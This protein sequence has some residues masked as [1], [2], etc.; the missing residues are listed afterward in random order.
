MKKILSALLSL[1]I[2][3][4]IA[5]AF[6]V[7]A[8]T[9]L[10]NATFESGLG[11]WTGRGSG[12]QVALS[13]SASVSG[14]QSASVTN[15]S[16]SWNGIEYALDSSTF[17]AGK[18]ISVSAQV[19]QGSSPTPVQFK[20]TVAYSNGGGGMG[21]GG[22]TTYDTFAT[23][24]PI[25]GGWGTL[26]KDGYTI[27]EGT[28]VLY[29]ETED[30]KCDFYVDDIII[31]EGSG[32][33]GS[34]DNPPSGNYQKG[35]VN[36]SG[37]VDSDDAYA[38]RDY[39][40][41]KNATVY[42]DTADLDGS[43]S[44]NAID[45]SKLKSLIMNPPVTTT[46]TTTTTETTVTT[47]GGGKTNAKEYMEM[48][49]PTLTKDVP[50][51]VKS[52]DNGKRVDFQYM[53]QKAGHNKKAICWLPP[54][55]TE[56]KKYN[57][58]YMSH[59]IFGDE[60]SMWSG[61]G[62][63]E[64]A[65]N[66]IQSGDAEP[67]III[68]TQM[69]TDPGTNGSPGFN[70]N[71]DVMDKYDDFVLDMRD[72]LMPYVEEHWSVMTG[73]EHTA[74]AGFSMGGRESLYLGMMLPDKIGYVC[75][76]SPAPGIVPASDAF[77]S[78]HLGSYNLARTARLTERDF[79]YSDSD[80]PYVLLIGGGTNDGTVGTF[81]KQY[82]ELYDKNGTTNL[83]MEFPGSGHDNSVGIP[84]FYNFYKWIFKA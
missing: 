12:V 68:F 77:L 66:M 11:G 67:F 31:V 76:S 16:E 22:G 81:P 5:S 65:S 53:S 2:M 26:S 18:T 59:G 57:V 17:P 55:Y 35:D 50:G 40:I 49:R 82:H 44:L 6:P 8:A 64:M 34:V 47:S 78:N 84:L 43:G 15:R 14:S 36:H 3:A 13:S 58:L 1:S 33:T 23:A 60:T 46:T 21:M 69:Y 54:G 56:S 24:T 20:M 80:L 74:V 48:I 37:A 61:W 52:G 79:K 45:L 42:K 10:M 39:L 72:S 29:I 73:R 32:G 27:G 9:E 41:C 30:S 19:M 63:R 70:I 25:A 62:V 4:G 71:M 51:N 75:A 7:T 28:A 38:L 83:W